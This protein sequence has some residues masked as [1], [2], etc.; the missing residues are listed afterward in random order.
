M[1]LIINDIL[2]LLFIIILENRY[3]IDAKSAPIIPSLL[4]KFARLFNLIFNGEGDEG[5]VSSF[6]ICP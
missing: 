4:I 2:K 5:T 1:V 6:V 3:E